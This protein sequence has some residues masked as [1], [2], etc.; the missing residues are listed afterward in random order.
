[1]ADRTVVCRV[2]LGAVTLKLT[3]TPKL[4]AKPLGAA[5]LTPFLGAYNKKTPDGRVQVANLACVK[6]DGVEVAHDDDS[7][8]CSELLP[9][10]THDIVLYPLSPLKQIPLPGL[11][12]S[13]ANAA[14]SGGG[15]AAS[16][17]LSS[18]PLSFPFDCESPFLFAV[19]HLDRYPPGQDNMGPDKR[20]L[21]GHSIGADFGNPAGWSMY[22]GEEGV[23]GF[24]KHPHRGFETITVT[25]RGLVDHTDSL[26]N[27]GRF[28][29]GDVQ[30]MT[31]GKGIS[32]AEMFPLLDRE[33]ENVLEL[34]QIWVNLPK[35]SK[36]VPP[37]FKMLWA[38]DI[39][40]Q[41]IDGAEITLVAGALPG[42]ASPAAP[43]PDSYAQPANGAE[44]LVCTIKLAAGASWTLPAVTATGERELNRNLYFYAGD[45]IAIADRKLLKHAKVKVDPSMSVAITADASGPAEVLVLQGR[46]IGEPT[47]QHGPFVGTTSDDIMKAFSDYQ[48]TGFGGWP[49]KSNA[50]AF[51]RDRPRF[52]KFANGELEER[53]IPTKDCA[54]K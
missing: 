31:A 16:P 36:M 49:W 2:A 43:P 44:F 41:T 26:G 37:S 22:H 24:P 10:D 17:V 3:L 15:L 11:T 54:A 14:G 53:P 25:R 45:K 42:L 28:G 6:I 21:K 33:N 8:A 32:H 29:Y 4:L 39:P 47:V 7:I 1:M 38:E 13:P 40:K 23:P 18:L 34:F 9:N 20:L 27:G 35:A 19:Y 51:P 5:V 48:A 12:T 46:D 50:L 52:A 30:W